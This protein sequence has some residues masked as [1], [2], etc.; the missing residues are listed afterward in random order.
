M[1]ERPFFSMQLVEGTT[2]AKKL[3]EGP[4][5]PR[6][7]A[8]LLSKVA[9]AIHYA[10]EQGVLHRDL[11]PSNILIDPDGQPRPSRMS[12]LRPMSRMPSSGANRYG[13]TSATR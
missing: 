12:S 9:R 8:E 13:G 3:A 2:L 11:K 4:I 1:T 6:E 5:P 7:A 10:H